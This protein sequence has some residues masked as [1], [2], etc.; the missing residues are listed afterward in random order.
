MVQISEKVPVAVLGATG[1]VGQKFI[2]LLADHPWFEIKALCASERS[3]GRD[4]ANAVHWLQNEPIPEP[5]AGMRVETCKPGDHYAL[6][7]SGLDSSVAGKVERAFADAGVTVVS[8]AKNHRMH[9]RVP[10]LVPEINGD[11]LSLLGAP[12]AR[13]AIVTNP[14]CATIGLVMALKPLHDRF[15]IEAV[16]VVTLQA[17]SGAGY[18]GVSAMDM[19]DNLVPYIPGEE[20]KL[21]QEPLKILG[22]LEGDRIAPAQMTIS[23]MCN[24]V[25]VADGH[26]ENISVKLR[27]PA[28]PEELIASWQ[29]FSS[30]AQALDLP[31]APARP[32]VYLDA[33]DAP[34]PRRHR[35]LGGG[36]TVSIGRLQTCPLMDYKFVALSHNTI[37]GAA[38]CALLN[39]ELMLAKGWLSCP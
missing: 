23:A 39:A 24:R 20:D 27:R 14:N 4:Y 10:L 26:M 16:H 6:A 38:G 9:P 2:M 28:R 21:V 1:S 30:E 29:G 7:F 13:G 11:H 3:A 31:S 17:L 35:D 5:I 15:G 37:R 32:I 25:P 22:A 8:N 12:P 18:P 36:M 34:Q 33:P 19:M